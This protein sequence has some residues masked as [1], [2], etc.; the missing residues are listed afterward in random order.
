[1]FLLNSIVPADVMDAT[2]ESPR[3]AAAVVHAFM[4]LTILVVTGLLAAKRS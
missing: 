3:A 4:M 1:M 2:I